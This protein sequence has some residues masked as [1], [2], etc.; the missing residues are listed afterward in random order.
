MNR[1]VVRSGT[2]HLGQEG[3]PDMDKFSMVRYLFSV[4]LRYRNSF[5][6]LS[7]QTH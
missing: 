5:S 1:M 4:D 3:G 7:R 6:I 2:G